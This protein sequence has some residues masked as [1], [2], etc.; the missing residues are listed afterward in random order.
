MFYF[1]GGHR[2]QQTFRV[3]T[4][5]QELKHPKDAVAYAGLTAVDIAINQHN[6]AAIRRLESRA[7]F[8]GYLALKSPR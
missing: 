1:A 3:T 4:Q 5:H 2:L 7:P 8:A 6:V